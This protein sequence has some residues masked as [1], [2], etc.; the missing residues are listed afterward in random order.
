[1]C[2]DSE[3]ESLFEP[4]EEN[5][6]FITTAQDSTQLILEDVCPEDTASYIIRLKTE[7]GLLAEESCEVAVTPRSPPEFVEFPEE[8]KCTEGEKVSITVRATG[9]DSGIFVTDKTAKASQNGDQFTIELIPNIEHTTGLFVLK[10]PGGES[11]KQI[12]TGFSDI[13]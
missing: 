1:M 5:G 8:V 3:G 2:K 11:Q 13:I 7:S 4:D 12:R 6:T 9:A 10:G